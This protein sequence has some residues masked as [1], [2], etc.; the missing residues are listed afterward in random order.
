M[1]FAAL[2][3]TVS[4]GAEVQL[5]PDGMFRS[6]DG[7][8]HNVPGFVMGEV[9]AQRLLAALRGRNND[10]VVDYEHQTLYA[11]SNGKPA[12]AAGWI[13]PQTIE[14]RPGSGLYARVRWTQTALAHIKADE[15][16]YLSPVLVYDPHTGEVLNLQHVA[17]TNSPAV[18]GMAAVEALRARFTPDN[19]EDHPV[20]REELIA[21][22]G[23]A[24]DATDEHIM[25][26]IKS[27]QDGQTQAAALRAE[28][29]MAEGGDAK[30]AVAALKAQVKP[31][32]SQ[33][34]PLDV[35]EALK[36]EI[37]ALRSTQAGSEVDGLVKQALVDGKLLPAQE[38][39]AVDLGNSNVAALKSYLA[40]TP[41]IAALKSSQT[42]GQ[43]PAG[44]GDKS[45]TLAAE[46]IAVLKQMGVSEADYL[47]TKAQEQ[48]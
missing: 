14:Y 33:Y 11:E 27:L 3:F 40:K 45:P 30:Q 28:L 7:R 1:A 2:R 12:P 39:W 44:A 10:I 48:R 5:T 38:G 4:E 46:E 9:V 21:L 20:N 37:A 35:V 31:D 47:A 18:D 32:L 42:N 13:D 19:Q 41:A 25:A 16:R 36:G 26:A 15:Y 17:L 24:A 6:I 22:L 23:L 34:A 43:P 29:G 8:P